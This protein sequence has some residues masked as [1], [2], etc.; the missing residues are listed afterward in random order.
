MRIVDF[1]QLV[2]NH[3]VNLNKELYIC[4][5]E[6]ALGTDFFIDEDDMGLY[7]VHSTRLFTENHFKDE[8]RR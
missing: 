1:I 7:L 2:L 8:E 5:D 3:N 6:E 4:A